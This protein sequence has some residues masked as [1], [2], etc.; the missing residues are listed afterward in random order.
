[1]I[2]NASF[3]IYLSHWF[4]LSILGKVLPHLPVAALGS[5]G[6]RATGL[7]VSLVVGILVYR[8]IE[9]RMSGWI[10]AWR[11]RTARSAPS[12]ENA[13]ADHGEPLSAP[14]PALALPAV[15]RDGSHTV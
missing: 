15:H 4:V 6:V 2:G 9:E 7:L 11:H 1:M 12:V 3:S 8:L 14:T 10:V 5:A 13:A